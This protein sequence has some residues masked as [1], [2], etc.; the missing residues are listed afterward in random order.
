ML[1]AGVDAVDRDGRPMADASIGARSPVPLAH[2][3]VAPL[4]HTRLRPAGRRGHL[5]V[6]DQA[7][8]PDAAPER[9][10]HRVGGAAVGCAGAR[11]EFDAVGG[12]G[13]TALD[14]DPRHAGPHRTC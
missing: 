13:G 14:H 3:A 4:R 7:A 10:C 11:R 2:V 9:D 12:A 5:G 6:P 8:Q 1:I